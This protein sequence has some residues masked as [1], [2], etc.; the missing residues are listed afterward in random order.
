LE[1][2]D[3]SSRASRPVREGRQVGSQRLEFVE[4]SEDDAQ[5]I[6]KDRPKE[7][8]AFVAHA[9][10]VDVD[11]DIGTADPGDPEPGPEP[12]VLL[13]LVCGADA[14]PCFRVQIM[15]RNLESRWP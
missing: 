1:S 9:L 10:D 7:I 3:C 12:R 14:R 13:F 8:I 4:P 11:G 2:R 5:E 15:L 6:L